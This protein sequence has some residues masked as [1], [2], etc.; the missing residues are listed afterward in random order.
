[1]SSSAAHTG[2]QA[3]QV[4]SAAELANQGVQSVVVST[5][6]L[7]ISIGEI[8]RQ[9]DGSTRIAA[10]A[11]A[12]VSSADAAV[13][14]L[15]QEA[16]QIG[17]VVEMIASIASRTNLLAL[18]ASI[19]A[20]R[21]GEAGR[22]FAVVASEVKNLAAQASHATEQITV[23]INQMQQGATRVVATIGAIG[24]VV[25][26]VDQIAAAIS[27]RSRS[28][29]PRRQ[30]L[31][32]MCSKPPRERRMSRPISPASAPRRDEPVRRAGSCWM[33]RVG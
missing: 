19:E 23:R 27:R 2:E 22:G 5:E 24:T 3:A 1:M 31:P 9:V 14:A 4:A 28:R 33:P 13:R 32:A 12:E 29:V 16:H 25:G 10:R 26:E 6:E 7:T 18:N 30:R 15:A 20:A 11:S 17:D 8:S 21:A